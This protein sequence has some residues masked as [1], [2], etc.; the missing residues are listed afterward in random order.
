M[1][2]YNSVLL[3][4]FF[5]FVA[6][7]SHDETKKFVTVDKKATAETKALLK[8]MKRLSKKGIMFGSED[9][10]LYGL[11]ADGSMWWHEKDRSDTKTVT[12]DFPAVYGWEIGDLELG[13]AISLDSVHFDTMRSE[14]IKV[15]E[16]NGINTMS[17]HSRNPLTGGNTWDTSSDEVVKSILPGGSKHELYVSWL[18][19]VAEFAHTLKVDNGTYVPVIFRPYHELNGGWFWWGKPH[20]MVED[21]KQLWIFT[22]EYLRDVKSVHHFLYAFSPNHGFKNKEQY[23]E[24]YPGDDYVDILGFDCYKRKPSQ[25]YRQWMSSSF[26]ILQQIAIEKDKLATLSETGYNNIPE[27][28]WWTNELLDIVKN[29][30]LS[31]VLVWR[32]GF[33]HEYYVSYEGTPSA[34]S[35]KMFRA[36]PHTLFQQDI[37]NEKIYEY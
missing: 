27:P 9:A 18:D 7:S 1:K 22:V 31:Y 24:S 13:H 34:A 8:N 14:I 37:V 32:N 21:Y 35:M 23:L 4:I 15:Y 25:N 3:F 36:D 16:R 19:R 17:W 12:G 2:V 5:L 28:N 6:C 33:S 11:N 20:R 30:Q 10:T 29:Y 26:N